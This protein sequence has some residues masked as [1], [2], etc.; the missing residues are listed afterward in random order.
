MHIIV[1]NAALGSS[2]SWRQL[3]LEQRN[4]GTPTSWNQGRRSAEGPAQCGRR[5][6]FFERGDRLSDSAV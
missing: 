3:R 4:F 1:L 2:T 6:R 5:P